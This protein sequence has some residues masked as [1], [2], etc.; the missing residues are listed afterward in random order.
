MT[1]ECTNRRGTALS[2]HSSSVSRLSFGPVSKTTVVTTTTTTTTTLPPMVMP[3]PRKR[4]VL[5]DAKQFPLF[6]APMPE[7]IKRLAL[8]VDGK[9]AFLRAVEGPDEQLEMIEDI[10]RALE[11]RDGT[12]ETVTYDHNSLPPRQIQITTSSACRKR[13]ASP[14]SLAGED[15]SSSSKPSRKPKRKQRQSDCHVYNPLHRLLLP[16][17]MENLT[18]VTELDAAAMQLEPSLSQDSIM[19]DAPMSPN[20]SSASPP[21]ISEDWEHPETLNLMR[22]PD[23][24]ATFDNVSPR[25]QPLVMY[26]LLRRCDKRTLQ[27]IASLVNPSLKRD[28]ITMLPY[29]LAIHVLKFL[30]A[31]SLCR[32]AQVSRGWRNIVDTD[33]SV[34]KERFRLDGY[35]LHDHHIQRAIHENWVGEDLDS[36]DKRPK[37]P[38]RSSK[39]RR[40]TE[41]SRMAIMSAP[42]P[43][44][45]FKAIYRRQ[46]I[47]RKNW[48]DP[49][50]QPHHITFNGHGRNVVTCLQFDDDKI[51]SGSD[52]HSINV[53][54]TRD[55]TL[56]RRMRGHEGGVWALE[57]VGNTLVSASTDRT[58]RIWDIETG[59]CTHVFG[60]HTQTVRCLQI[61]DGEKLGE[62]VFVTGSRDSSLRVWR[63]PRPKDPHYDFERDDGPNPFF[64]RKL[65]G[66]TQSVRAIAGQD[67][68]LVSGSY[69]NNVKLWTVSTGQCVHTYVGHAAKVYSVALD[70]KKGKAVSGSMDCFVKVWDLVGG[71]CLYTLEGHTSLVGLLSLSHRQLVSAAADSTLRIWN[72]DS[73]QCQHILTAHTGAI[74]CFQH[75]D[76]KVISGSDGNVK[77]WD[78]KTGR[79]IRD[80][81][82]GLSGVWQI[83]FDE[84]RCVA[85]VQRNQET[86][87][88]VLDFGTELD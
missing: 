13:P 87:F 24:V 84:R 52:D 71:D 3:A 4:D 56:L 85:A 86:C 73:G 48:M 16:T 66:H 34:W 68:L 78:I 25:V 80:I 65:A 42:L 47:L 40:K 59:E 37:K 74:T 54:S 60:G 1:S 6:D 58:V 79:F 49:D 23:L 83:K 72:P 50:R 64:L 70:T 57:Y 55:G 41:D 51:L 5:L 62:K 69:D 21:R 44:R 39:R 75:D 28:F 33:E 18:P 10:A 29:E 19:D 53:S 17:E 38:L 77:I 30:D 76:Q 22:L 9:P 88:E 20:S 35:T 31:Q 61:M 32:A 26:H 36:A 12:L 81:L 67:D 8:E 15:A 63:L 2:R 43:P 27:F 7:S 46:D 14:V 45:L 82:T 11:R